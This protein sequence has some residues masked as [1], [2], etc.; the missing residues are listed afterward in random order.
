[1][2]TNP[3]FKFKTMSPLLLVADLDRS[4][5]FYVQNLGFEV[6]FL[7]ED[8]YAGIIKDGFSI[9]LKL[10]ESSADERQNRRN[11]GHIDI[12]FAIE[13]VAAWYQCLKNR[14]VEIVQP[15][16]DMP[17]GQEFYIEDPD[18]YILAFLG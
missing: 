6:D 17:Y 14:L 9:H 7:Y 11:N 5:E 15:L 4:L 2:N 10:A 18:G 13:M 16:R 1:M 8:F 3:T 12:T